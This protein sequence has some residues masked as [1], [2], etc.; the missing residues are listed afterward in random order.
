[1]AAA[2]HSGG[3]LAEVAS[4]VWLWMQRGGEPRLA[5]MALPVFFH[6]WGVGWLMRAIGAVPSSYGDAGRALGKGCGVLAFPGGVQEA[7]RP[8]WRAD[9]VEFEGHK[10]FLRIARAARVPVV[11]VG[12]QGS[13]VTA[14]VLWRSRGLAWVLGY[15]LLGVRT[16]A[17]SVLGVAGAC[18][19]LLG[20]AASVARAVAALAWL[21]C[22]LSVLLPWVPSNIRIRVGEPIAP[23]DLFP[24]ADSEEQLEAALRRVEG[25]VQ[26]LVSLSA[27]EAS[28]QRA[29]PTPP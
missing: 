8:V 3:G 25:E 29:C 13:H 21:A 26:D 12:I 24:G 9:R 10:G 1:M 7:V 28:G 16:G 17:V 5:G 27:L 19:I 18:A 20:G 14:P 23:E 4:L 22:P 11:P 15:R 6:L 2:N